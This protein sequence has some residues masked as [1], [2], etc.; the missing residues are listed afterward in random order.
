[1]KP[2]SKPS[3]HH[4]PKLKKKKIKRNLTYK[5]PSTRL[6]AVRIICVEIVMIPV[7]M[8][9]V[10]VAKWLRNWIE[11]KPSIANQDLNLKQVNLQLEIGITNLQRARKR[12]ELAKIKLFGHS[13]TLQ[14]SHENHGKT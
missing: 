1:M 14:L 5:I 13:K 6:K 11:R 7:H 12:V 9:L 10:S 2:N 4:M 3:Y 8:V